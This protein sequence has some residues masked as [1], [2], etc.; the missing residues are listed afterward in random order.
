[1]IPVPL[2][3]ATALFFFLDYLASHETGVEAL[4]AC[5]LMESLLDFVAR[6]GTQIKNVIF[7]TCAVR[8]IDLITNF[9]IINAFEV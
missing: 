1:M 7:V 5:G 3:L 6:P 2:P 9:D 8:V 4:V